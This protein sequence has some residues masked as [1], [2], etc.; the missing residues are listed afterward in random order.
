PRGEDRR[1]VTVVAQASHLPQ[2][3]LTAEES[4]PLVGEPVVDL[5]S[6]DPR[7]L[8]DKT[9]FCHAAESAFAV[10]EQVEALGKEPFKEAWAITPTIENDCQAAFPYDGTHLGEDLREPPHPPHL[11]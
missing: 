4:H 1:L 3:Q 2:T 9:R 5:S 6:V 11:G 10:G 8:L 7:G